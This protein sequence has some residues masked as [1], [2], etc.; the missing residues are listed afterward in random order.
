MTKVHPLE[1][2]D[3]TRDTGMSKALTVNP[4]THRCLP[5]SQ[6][7]LL[8]GHQQRGKQAARRQDSENGLNPGERQ[9]KCLEGYKQSPGLCGGQAW[10]ATTPERSAKVCRRNISKNK[11]TGGIYNVINLVENC[12][13][14]LA[15]R[16][17]GKSLAVDTKK[18]K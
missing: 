5:A 4:C 6:S 11:L 13:E 7:W 8:D 18:P 3:R 16:K 1:R 15:T 14:K 10:E 2:R 17:Y 12:S 9:R